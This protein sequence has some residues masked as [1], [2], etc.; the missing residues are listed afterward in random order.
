[1]G[2]PSPADV[3][4]IN[5]VGVGVRHPLSSAADADPR[6][7]TRIKASAG[8]TVE[9]S[10]GYILNSTAWFSNA[11]G[12]LPSNLKLILYDLPGAST[13]A[14]TKADLDAMQIGVR[15]NVDDT[16]QVWVST[17]WALVD[18]IP[19]SGTEISDNQ[20]IHLKG[21]QSFSDTQS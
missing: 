14:W 11:D 3:D 10:A 19:T 8:G 18:Y 7:V 6:F 20:P 13:T 4:T 12:T 5:V 16:D 2:R 1:M 9:E 17:L 15:V 21:R